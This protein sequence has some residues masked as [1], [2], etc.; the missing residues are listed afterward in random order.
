MQQIGGDS[1]DCIPQKPKCR[2]FGKGLALWNAVKYDEEHCF[3]LPSYLACL[4]EL[5]FI[6]LLGVESRFLYIVKLRGV[7]L[8]VRKIF[9]PQSKDGRSTR[10]ANLCLPPAYPRRN[11]PDFAIWVHFARICLFPNARWVSSD[12]RPSGPGEEGGHTRDESSNLSFR[13]S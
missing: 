11:E 12:S 3:Y 5:H 13:A 9:V 2:P 1:L 8:Q 10:P 6:D 4:F 7:G